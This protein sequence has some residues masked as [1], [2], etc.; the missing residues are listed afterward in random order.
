M[1]EGKPLQLSAGQAGPLLA[2]L[3]LR[4]ACPGEQ[5]GSLGRIIDLEAINGNLLPELVK[6]VSIEASIAIASSGMGDEA[7]RAALHPHPR[8][9]LHRL[10][11]M[12]GGDQLAFTQVGNGA[13]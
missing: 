11:D 9:V 1:R 6:Q 4:W 8:S 12:I 5:T 3:P 10:G 2:M 7:D 13:C